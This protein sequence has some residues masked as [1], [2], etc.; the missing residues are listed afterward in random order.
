[1]PSRSIV[2]ELVPSFDVPEGA[3]QPECVSIAWSADAA[4]AE[5]SIAGYQAFRDRAAQATEADFP[6]G[7]IR[8]V[9]NTRQPAGP[10]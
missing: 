7:G 9:P 1:M 3:R 6:Q 2:D 8:L 5:G 10:P 4:P